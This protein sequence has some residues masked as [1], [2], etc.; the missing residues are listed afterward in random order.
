MQNKQEIE[1]YTRSIYSRRNGGIR[2]VVPGLE[3]VLKP[4]WQ[5]PVFKRNKKAASEGRWVTIYLA[6]LQFT[7]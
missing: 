4:G 5:R 2:T 1:N 7:I 3:V 6:V